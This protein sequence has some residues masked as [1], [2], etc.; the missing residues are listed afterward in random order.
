MILSDCV[1]VARVEESL[2][3]TRED[4]AYT[5]NVLMFNYIL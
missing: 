4:V 3:V 5:H 1:I 2:E